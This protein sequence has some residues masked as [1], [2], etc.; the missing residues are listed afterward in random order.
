MT[1][2]N[3]RRANAALTACGTTW[4]GGALTMSTRRGINRECTLS[5]MLVERRGIRAVCAAGVSNAF[6]QTCASSLDAAQT[7]VAGSRSKRPPGASLPYS[8]Q[9]TRE[10]NMKGFGP[11]LYLKM[12][13][14]VRVVDEETSEP[15]G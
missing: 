10:H 6:G 2:P 15:T 9:A 13:R 12:R 7:D 11:E 4:S 3:V 8:E 5:S 14:C 1:G